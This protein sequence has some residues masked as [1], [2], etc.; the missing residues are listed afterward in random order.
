MD[1]NL[2]GVNIE[3]MWPY[4]NFYEFNKDHKGKKYSMR[5]GKLLSTR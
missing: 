2:T 5:F 1:L 4:S 3:N